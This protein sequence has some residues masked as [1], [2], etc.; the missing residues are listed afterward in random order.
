VDVIRIVVN[1]ASHQFLDAVANTRVNV[2]SSSSETL[3]IP[4]ISLTRQQ[5]EWLKNLRQDW[6]N[7]RM[8]IYLR[9]RSGIRAWEESKVMNFNAPIHSP[10]PE[11]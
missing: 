2:P 4:E 10:E 1:V 3:F 5:T 7:A 9:C 11:Y 6:V 8:E